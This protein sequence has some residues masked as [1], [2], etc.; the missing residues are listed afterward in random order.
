MSAEPE[1]FL[2]SFT[3]MALDAA[4]RHGRQSQIWVQAFAVPEG[5]EEELGMGLRV[6]AEMGATH[7]AAWGYDGTASMSCVRPARPDV[8]WRVVCE[9]FAELRGAS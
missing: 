2:R 7:V 5:R 6:A 9:A 1:P 8:V 4:A 3:R